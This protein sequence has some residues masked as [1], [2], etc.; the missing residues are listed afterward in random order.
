MGFRVIFAY[1]VFAPPVIRQGG[2]EE[3][4]DSRI[5]RLKE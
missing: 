1:F 2:V 3:L 5:E 4:R